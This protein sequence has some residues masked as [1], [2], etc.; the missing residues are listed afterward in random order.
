MTHH[1]HGLILCHLYKFSGEHTFGPCNPLVAGPDAFRNSDFG[2][3]DTEVHI[4]MSHPI[5]LAAFGFFN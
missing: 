3:L 5:A 4:L 2:G 1:H